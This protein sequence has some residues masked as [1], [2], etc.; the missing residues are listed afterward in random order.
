MSL[1][2]V[3]WV[4]F[5]AGVRVEVQAEVGSIGMWGD[6]DG[7]GGAHSGRDFI[8]MKPVSGNRVY[9]GHWNFP[10]PCLRSY[11]AH[12]AI[13]EMHLNSL[14]DIYLILSHSARTCIEP[15][16]GS[17]SCEDLQDARQRAL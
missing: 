6:R 5:C 14:L 1:N 12:A 3:G 15:V 10:K 8:N 9:S 11:S 2:H 13:S 17:P 4:R 7:G 16:I